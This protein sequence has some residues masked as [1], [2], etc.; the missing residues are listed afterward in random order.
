MMAS[1]GTSPRG[2]VMNADDPKEITKKKFLPPDAAS[3]SLSGLAFSPVLTPCPAE[4]AGKAA[5]QLT[6]LSRM[7]RLNS[8]VWKP[9]S[10]WGGV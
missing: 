9:H 2:G 6:A 4:G 7:D 5:E 10:S 8:A 3:A 1:L